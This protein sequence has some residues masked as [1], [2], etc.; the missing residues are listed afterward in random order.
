MIRIS[1]VIPFHN[2][3][4]YIT[5]CI[6]EL[7]SQKYPVEHYE[8]VMV[9]NNST[10]RSAEIVRRYARVKLVSE[11]KQGAYVARNRGVREARGEIIAFTD[12]DCV[13][14]QDWL[15]EI[16]SAM[17]DSQVGIVIGSHQLARDSFLLSL[18]EDYEREKNNYI[19]NSEI[20]ELYYGYARNMAIRKNLFG[21][22]GPF[23]ERARGSDVIF[24]HRCIDRYSCAAVRYSPQIQVRHLEIETPGKYF[25]KV[26]I[27]GSSSQRYGQLVG[28]RPLTM[29]ERFLVFRQ[30]V[31]SQR[32]PWIKSASL[33]GLLAVGLVYW[34][35]GSISAAWSFRKYLMS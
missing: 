6:E 7:L 24:V 13:P 9:D 4:R 29:R 8:I 31:Q 26:F 12:A 30:T 10:D 22:I 34:V 28:A 3:E 27:Y 15:Q 1:V 25:R 17:A 19:F 11:K 5:K 35:L 20:K 2:S 14:S 32:Y 23:V 33:F 18:L 16:E 21:E